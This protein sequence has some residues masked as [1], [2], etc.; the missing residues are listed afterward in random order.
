MII[1]NENNESVLIDVI[2]TY[3]Y[4]IQ[5]YHCVFIL[6]LVI[7]VVIFVQDGDPARVPTMPRA[8]L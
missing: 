8:H 7:N 2:Q 5:S 1:F 4:F 3:L 6:D